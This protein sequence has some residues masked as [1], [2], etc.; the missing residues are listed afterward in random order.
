M[1]GR[2]ACGRAGYKPVGS[3]RQ[4][5][6]QARRQAPTGFGLSAYELRQILQAIQVVDGAGKGD[7]PPG[8]HVRDGGIGRGT[9]ALIGR[10]GH[11]FQL[12]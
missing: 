11:L 5:V 9:I 3:H 2:P 10:A 1:I 4:S 6:S 12:N 7:P 8:A